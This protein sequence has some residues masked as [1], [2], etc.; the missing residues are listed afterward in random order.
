MSNIQCDY[1]LKVLLWYIIL[2]NEKLDQSI[3]SGVTG[4]HG[5]LEISKKRP[6]QSFTDVCVCVWH[7]LLSLW[8]ENWANKRNIER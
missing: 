8:G 4:E 3:W 6:T 7:K 2:N 5:L 1:P